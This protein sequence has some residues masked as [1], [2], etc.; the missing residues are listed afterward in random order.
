MDRSGVAAC[1]IY[2]GGLNGESIPFSTTGPISW[3]HSRYTELEP[4][5]VRIYNRWLAD[6]V[7]DA[8]DRHIGIAHLPTERKSSV[9]GKGV[10]VRGALGCRRINTKN[11]KQTNNKI[12]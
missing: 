7:S 3:G 1:V 2:H 10:S 6:F 8:P 4:V 9:Y 12:K 11:K 5:G